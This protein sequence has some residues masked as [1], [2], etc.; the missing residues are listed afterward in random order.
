MIDHAEYNNLY[1]R[2]LGVL[3]L[4]ENASPHVSEEDREVIES[5]MADAI[6]H[7]GNL[8][9]KRILNRVCIEVKS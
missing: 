6:R 5:A 9:T 4:L 8:T 2:Y 3:K 1:M 7:H